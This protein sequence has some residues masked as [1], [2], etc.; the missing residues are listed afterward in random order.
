MV[1][2]DPGDPSARVEALENQLA[3]HH[4]ALNNAIESR[5][6]ALLSA[7]FGLLQMAA[8]A[9]VFWISLD[10]AQPWMRLFGLSPSLGLLPSVVIAA[11]IAYGV[12]R[13]LSG[14]VTGVVERGMK[15]LPKLPEWQMSDAND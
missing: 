10:A 8:G 14:V 13:L 1:V 15:R 9:W 6:G 11:A 5:D 3:E 7:T 12:M 4:V 2:S